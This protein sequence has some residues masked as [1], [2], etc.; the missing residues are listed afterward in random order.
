MFEDRDEG[1]C[2]L[3][4]LEF[5]GGEEFFIAVMGDRLCL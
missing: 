4:A 5:S 3:M 2:E 1:R